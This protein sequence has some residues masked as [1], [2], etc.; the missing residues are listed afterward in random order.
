MKR[1]VFV[2]S[3][4]CLV[5][6]AGCTGKDYA[7]EAEKVLH[8]QILEE[9]AWAMEQSPETVTASVCER[10][11]GGP[12]DFYSEGDYW[13]PN[14]EDPEGPFIRRDGETNPGNFIAHRLVMIRFSRVVGALASAYIVTGDDKFV[15]QAF[16]HIN[17]WFCDPATRMNANLQFAQAIKGI[18]PGRGVGIID[19]I[20]LMEVAQGV[21]RM[22]GSPAAD[23]TVLAG[24]KKWFSD[25][26]DWMTTSK[27]GLDELKA[28]NNHSVCWVMQVASFARL[29]GNAEKLEFCRARF[30]DVL[31]PDQMAADGS[32]PR[33]IG[34]TKP[35][36]YSLFNLDA[37]VAV[38][39]IISPDGGGLWSYTTPDGR[40]IRKAID[41][42]RPYIDNKITWP[43]GRD[44][45]YWDEWPVAHPA[46]LFA[47]TAYD[48]RE[49]LELWKRL[50]HRI[51]SG[52]LNAMF[53]SGFQS[54]GCDPL[55][56]GKAKGCRERH[57]WSEKFRSLVLLRAYCEILRYKSR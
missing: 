22:E 25:Y 17:A 21:I 2:A 8:A 41:F 28:T 15:E 13:W 20:H 27:N 30:T 56:P 40:N 18:T 52:G 19:T 26:I 1:T 31:L 12:H 54:S 39:S 55:F 37:M 3:L 53:R 47:A 29:T 33:E 11:E 7:R 49:Y 57:E 23:A 42:M 50:P 36:G 14:P 44:V 48:D 45:M 35:Y 34:R 16:K 38:C 32:F 51:A 9:A 24:T 43:H 6:A 5:F 4:L 10:S 46:L